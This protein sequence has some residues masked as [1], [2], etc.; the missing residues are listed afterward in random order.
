MTAIT[1]SLLVPAFLAAAVS[2]VP[3]TNDPKGYLA[4][5]WGTALVESA[6]LRLAGDSD[7]IKEYEPTQKPPRFGPITVDAVRYV[8]VEGKFARV[9]IRYT[10]HATHLRVVE[11]L[12]AQYGPLDRTPG[13][14]A[15]GLFQQLNW[16]GPVS[17]LNL[18]YDVRRERGL[19]F[20]ESRDYAVKFGEAAD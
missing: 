18:T 7:R 11:Y 10:G 17:E 20:L 9:M 2:A 3:M 16:R 12:E 8:T 6:D 5:P 13:Q 14:L 15:A 4:L 19:I 1:A